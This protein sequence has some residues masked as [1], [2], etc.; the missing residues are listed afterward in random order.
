MFRF[1]L[2]NWRQVYN[3]NS[4]LQ[5]PAVIQKIAVI[6]SSQSA[7]LHDFAH[8]IESNSFGYKF[9]IT[10]YF[11]IVQ[12]E[13]KAELFF[14]KLIEVFNS[15]IKYDVVVIIRGGGAQTDFLIFDQFIL[16]KIVA[17]FPIPIITG[18]GHQKNET[19]VDLMANTATKTPTKA[20]EFI[21]AHNRTLEE[22]IVALQK[23]II[24]RS[25]QLFAS[26]SSRLSSLNSIVVNNSRNLIS[27]H[28]EELFN[29]N[30]V[31]VNKTKELLF[32]KNSSLVNIA[33]Q[34]S[35]KPRVIVSTKLHDLTNIISNL[36]TFNSQ[37]LKNQR[38]YLNHYISMARAMAPDN[39]LKKGFAIIKVNNKI[40]SDPDDIQVG[41]DMS[42][43][44][45]KKEIRSTVKS[46][47]DYNGNDF[48]L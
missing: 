11:T 45:D 22:K 14:N 31:I 9:S 5:L 26:N 38:S 43:I 28:K 17:K 20:A 37:Y 1:H 7:G 36:K 39:I 12:G 10:N 24:I 19:I 42:V 25:Q 23:T 30:Q 33:S 44:L 16:A 6:T 15:G 47:T 13:A 18:I 8:T 46:K 27:H 29:T 21:I 41:N 40:T 34:L 4:R 35:S 2:K 3:P 32:R 48:N